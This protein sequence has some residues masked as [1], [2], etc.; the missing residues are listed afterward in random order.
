M[1]AA[2]GIGESPQFQKRVRSIFS[3]DGHCPSTASP[4]TPWVGSVTCETGAREAGAVELS[5]RVLHLG[6]RERTAGAVLP[7]V[8]VRP[9]ERHASSAGMLNGMIIALP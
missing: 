8:P 1:S 2:C 5:Q 6:S 9:G 4:N 7:P 3:A